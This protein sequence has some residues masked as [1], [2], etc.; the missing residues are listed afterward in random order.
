MMKKLLLLMGLCFAPLAGTAGE[1]ATNWMILNNSNSQ[2]FSDIWSRF[3]AGFK[4]D[5]P[6]GDR[7]KYYEKLYTKNPQNFNKLMANAIPYLYF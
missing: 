7:V 3:R 2:Q 1:I 6:Q 5:H 4:L